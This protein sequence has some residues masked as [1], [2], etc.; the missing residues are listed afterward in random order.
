MTLRLVALF[1]AGGIVAA[2]TTRQDWAALP[3]KGSWLIWL[4]VQ[5]ISLATAVNPLYSLDAIK[6][7]TVYGFAAYMLLFFQSRE[8]RIA[9]RLVVIPTVVL[10]ILAMG[11]AVEWATK[12]TAVGPTI[13]YDGVGAFTTY[14]ITVIP[15][16]FAIGFG[17]NP[18]WGARLTLAAACLLALTTAYLGANRMFWLA[19]AVEVVVMARLLPRRA[20][21]YR[22]GWLYGLG[23]PLVL[24]LIAVV[25]YR[26]LELRTGTRLDD[27]ER[28]VHATITHDPR[29]PL[30]AFC[31]GKI[32]Q[33]PLYGVGFGL[34][35]FAMAYPQWPQ[36][37]RL[38]W[39]AH[40]LFLNYGIEMGLPG[41]GV[42]LWLIGGL[43]KS[44]WSTYRATRDR[45]RRLVAVVAV[46]VILG[47]LAKNMT[48][49]FFYQDLALLFWSLMGGMLG[50]FSPAGAAPEPSNDPGSSPKP[51]RQVRACG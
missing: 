20:D 29:W 10:V 35:A 39:H 46:T 15:V 14:A 51:P 2:R 18:K 49:D 48:D 44:F 32:V 36:H 26:V 19:F 13:V 42:F 45:E 33:H 6:A 41:I 3:L 34:H 28:V 9:R 11:G 25:F 16:A 47:V 5:L 4:A 23:I 38:L 37:N 30:W 40:N 50:Y 24:V 17:G 22:R 12:G 7:Q 1:V 8:P 43:L 31:V 21:A 27:L